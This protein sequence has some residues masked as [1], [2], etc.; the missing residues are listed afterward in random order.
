MSF[1][2]AINVPLTIKGLNI[3]KT[4]LMQKIW[5][6]ESLNLGKL[7]GISNITVVIF[8]RHI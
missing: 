2:L 8:K 4:L 6:V 3:F 5:V 7:K 1:N